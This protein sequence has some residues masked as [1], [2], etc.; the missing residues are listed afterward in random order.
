MKIYEVICDDGSP[1]D[2]FSLG[3]YLSKETAEKIV[4][5]CRKYSLSAI[6]GY[7]VYSVKEHEISDEISSATLLYV[8]G[9]KSDYF[10]V[11]E[12]GLI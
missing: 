7:E 5:E 8:N 6:F 3:F 2:L 11:K 1:E 9:L 12:E 4:D 10:Q